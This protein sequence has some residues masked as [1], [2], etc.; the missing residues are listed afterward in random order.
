[1]KSR[2]GMKQLEIYVFIWVFICFIGIVIK[3]KML[4][5][6]NFYFMFPMLQVLQH[7]FAKT[8]CWIGIDKATDKNAKVVGSRPCILY[9]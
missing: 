9:G 5:V 3:Y 2:I 1:M 4:D 8:R 6:T 7:C